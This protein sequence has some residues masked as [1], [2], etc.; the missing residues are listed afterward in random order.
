M[1]G[2]GVLQSN[3]FAGVEKK[4]ISLMGMFAYSIPEDF[5]CDDIE[6]YIDIEP[7]YRVDEC[8]TDDC[9]R[10]LLKNAEN[11]VRK[12]Y[13]LVLNHYQLHNENNVVGDIPIKKYS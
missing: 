12:K 3:Y 7:E 1:I 10:P 9:L 11:F 2:N 8:F 5:R 6:V 4:F 13:G